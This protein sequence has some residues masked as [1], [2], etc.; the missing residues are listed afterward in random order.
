MLI[1][2]RKDV[3]NTPI[4]WK[5]ILEFL[6][7]GACFGF[8]GKPLH[9]FD[10][11]HFAEDWQKR[12]WSTWKRQA[13]IQVGASGLEEPILQIL[14]PIFLCLSSSSQLLPFSPFTNTHT[15]VRTCT[16]THTCAMCTCTHAN[17]HAHSRAHMHVYTHTNTRTHVHM[18]TQ[19][20]MHMY[21][22]EHMCTHA[23]THTCK[24]MR[25]HTHMQTHTHISKL[26]RGVLCIRIGSWAEKKGNFSYSKYGVSNSER[27]RKGVDYGRIFPASPP[28]LFIIVS[29]FV[30]DS[31]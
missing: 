1:I 29:V 22:H 14:A 18:H 11:S 6:K 23:C 20:R 24:H 28:T 17:T 30:Y 19:T 26:Q 8:V 31:Y 5:V 27:R 7:T 15:C 10:R 13:G 9:C 2:S 25:S 16:C 4:V 12:H 3:L 21:K